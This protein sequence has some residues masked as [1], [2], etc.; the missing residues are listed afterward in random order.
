MIA[1]LPDKGKCNKE[2]CKNHSQFYIRLSLAVNKKHPPASSG[3]MLWVCAD[4]IDVKW[5][6]LVSNELWDTICKSFL[7]MGRMAPLKEFS[8]LEIIEKK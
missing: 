5:D 8:S 1:G 4:H 7:K 2:G 3:P 6:D